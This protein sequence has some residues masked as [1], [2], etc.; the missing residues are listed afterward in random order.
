MMTS[1]RRAFGPS[2]W[3]KVETPFEIASSP[4]SDDPPLAKA[5]STMIDPGPVQKAAP[6]RADGHDAGVV[7]RV[8]VQLAERG[9]D[10]ADDDHR[11]GRGDEQ[12][13]R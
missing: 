10:E 5:R 2:G 9:A 6:G 13:S 12:V 11:T 8:R 7:D 1:T 3:R 4:V